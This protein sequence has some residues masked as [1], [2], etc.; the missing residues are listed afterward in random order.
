MWKETKTITKRVHLLNFT[1]SVRLS[2]THT[3]R[4]AH[5][6]GPP[7]EAVLWLS[8]CTLLPL[9]LAPLAST[10]ASGEASGLLE[11]AGV[12]E[13]LEANTYTQAPVST[14]EPCHVNLASC[15]GLR[16]PGE[17]QSPGSDLSVLRSVTSVVGRVPAAG[18]VTA[19]PALGNTGHLRA[20]LCGGH[21][22][23][24][25]RQALHLIASQLCDL[26]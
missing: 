17:S 10:Q 22:K 19:S 16:V 9:Y 12:A 5:A 2:H 8:P 7:R 6:H 26:G 24:A 15:E 4:H 23:A 11:T 21:E 13:I 14:G 1:L 3:H 18:R 20:A 25:Q